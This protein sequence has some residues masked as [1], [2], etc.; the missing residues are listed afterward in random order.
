MRE[1]GQAFHLRVEADGDQLRILAGAASGRLAHGSIAAAGVFRARVDPP[2]LVLPGDDRPMAELEAQIGRALAEVWTAGAV[3]V[4]LGAALARARTEPLL[5]VVDTPDPELG[6][7]PWEL[8][9]DADGSGLEATGR[10]VVARR[11][12]GGAPVPAEGLA[13]TWAWCPDPSDPVAEGLLGALAVPSTP[14]AEGPLVTFVVAHG[15]RAHGALALGAPGGERA[16]SGVVHAL[17][18]A[19]ARSALVVLAVCDA[20]AAE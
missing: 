16:G 19:L 12:G 2:A 6:A 8:L 5:I 11:A 14:A 4:E 18:P 15:T 10:A 13:S 3:A 7:L 1:S 17:V 9:A 20:G